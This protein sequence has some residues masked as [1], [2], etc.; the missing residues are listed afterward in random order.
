[1]SICS[2]SSFD[3]KLTTK[4]TWTATAL[5][6]RK[7]IRVETAIAT[8]AR[9]TAVIQATDETKGR[10][11]DRHFEIIMIDAS[12]K[13]QIEQASPPS[14]LCKGLDG[15]IYAEAGRRIASS[16][17]RSVREENSPRNGWLCCRASWAAFVRSVSAR[18]EFL[19]RSGPLKL[20]SAHR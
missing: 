15:N 11:T 1:M 7:T 16:P 9:F 13:K 18:S 10:R 6:R 14:F 3:C 2:S 17:S 20:L 12:A 5:F 19:K 8:P 4:K